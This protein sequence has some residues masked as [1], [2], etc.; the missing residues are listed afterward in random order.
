MS[1]NMGHLPKGSH[2]RKMKDVLVVAPPLNCKCS[3]FTANKICHVIRLFFALSLEMCPSKNMFLCSASIEKICFY[4]MK[5]PVIIENTLS[6][7]C[8]D[9]V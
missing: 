1:A 3:L 5:S 9:F 4:E 2:L 8:I 7:L 6:S